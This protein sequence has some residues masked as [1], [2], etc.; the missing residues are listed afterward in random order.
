MFGLTLNGHG[1]PDMLT[2]RR[3]LP[4]PELA[5]TDVLIKVGAAGVNNT[6]I[7]TR[8]GWYSKGDNDAADASW[9]GTPLPFPLI[10]GIDA[11]GRI[12][13]VGA[14][15]DPARIGE[16]VL[17]EPCLTRA[18]GVD[19]Q[20]PRFLGS[21][22]HG[23]FAEFTKVD[24]QHAYPINS[25]LTDIELASFPCSYSTA[26]NMLTRANLQ[27][28]ETVLITGAS[29]GVGS[30]AVQLARARG[31]KVI[32]LTNAAM[33]QDLIALGADRTFTR[34]D[35]LRSILGHHTVDVVIDLVAGPGFAPLLDILRP[36]GRY[37]VAGAV[38]G[39]IV[40]LDVRTLY[41]KDLTFVGCTV[42]DKDVFQSLVTRIETGQIKPL[43]AA[44]FRLDK[45]ADA[46]EAFAQKGFVGK[47]VLTPPA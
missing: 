41:L 7:N 23:A 13:D 14:D 33:R 15:I 12:T 42:L 22:C 24:A 25:P 40:E 21:D 19:L 11:V 4:L 29:G 5:P 44:T 6:D 17:V 34:D 2:F 31:A 36:K 38:A 10:Q 46:Q 26:E 39:P 9:S 18:N 37:A 28:G 8:L 45:A 35:D 20:R 27:K 47:I 1:G 43:I 3:D 30:A 16:R 32:A